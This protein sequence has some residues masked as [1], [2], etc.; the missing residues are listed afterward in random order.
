MGKE[1]AIGSKVA[2]SAS[3]IISK[4]HCGN[5]CILTEIDV[6]KISLKVSGFIIVN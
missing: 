5:I 3:I 2:F 1:I 4:S 6:E